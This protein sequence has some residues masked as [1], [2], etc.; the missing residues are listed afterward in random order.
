MA[1]RSDNGE[2]SCK[3]IKNGERAGKWRVQHVVVQPSGVKKRL[4]RT[5]RSQREAKDFLRSLKRTDERSAYQATKETTF[6][7][8]FTWLSENDWPE[9][10]N[11]K[12]LRDRVARYSKY[13]AP[14]WATVPLSKIDPLEVKAYY[15]SLR[16]QGVGEHT[17][18][19]LK[20]ALVRAFNQAITPYR[21]VPHFWG[22]PFRLDMPVPARRQAVALT[23]AEAGEA[24]RSK[25]L[26]DSRRAFLGVFLL[27][28]LRLS[29]QMALTC[30]QVHESIGL[31]EIDRA[32]KL[33]K[34]SAQTV[35]LPKGNKCRQAVLSNYLRD[36]LKPLIDGKADDAFIWPAATENKPRMKK[37][38]Y[39]TWRTIVKDAKLPADMRPRDCRLTH[40]NWIE[41]LLPD[42]STTTLKEHVG[43][44]AQGVTEVNYT[45]PLS[46]AQAGLRNGLDG[47]MTIKSAEKDVLAQAS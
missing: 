45:R 14:R 43:H 40:I 42:V 38:V 32:V 30:G 35:G 31:I 28:G 41:K 24:L 9:A 1:T 6:G 44:A 47:L 5:F 13:A 8:W 3:E 29:E 7:E 12:T 33:G 19:A 15:Q 20:A 46:S 10:I 17:R 26:D 23:P 34:T 18:I 22:N 21:R 39:A 4:S 16:E 25:A 2:G 11:E 37:L 36:L 27:A